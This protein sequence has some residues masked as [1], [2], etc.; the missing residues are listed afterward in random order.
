MSVLHAHIPLSEKKR[1]QILAHLEDLLE[2][3]AFA[4]SRRRQAFLR[5]VVEETLAGRGSAI[6]ET[7]IAVDV[8]GRS[9]DFDAQTASI[10]RVTAAEVRKRIAQAY[11]AGLRG[12]LHI[13]LPLGGYQPT[14]QFLAP[15]ET[16][17]EP[18]AAPPAEAPARGSR[19]LLWLILAVAACIVVAVSSPSVARMVRPPS[20]T[21]LLLRPFLDRNNPVLI[22]LV[23]VS[24]WL[25][26]KWFTKTFSTI[27]TCQTQ[28]V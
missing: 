16:L 7:N 23:N 17:E 6:K 27:E 4:G 5:Y 24:L 20:A 13:D 8:F 22:S 3:Q 12:N 15:A 26:R 28:R 14:F 19:P 2:S 18:L 25:N 11:E 9:N 10:V 21:D 1:L